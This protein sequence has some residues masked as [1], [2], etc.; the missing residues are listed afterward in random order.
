[1]K[2]NWTAVITCV[3]AVIGAGFASGREIVSFFTRYG[4]D[5]WW[6]ILLSVCVM[7]ALCWLCM[8]GAQRC[9][10]LQNWCL[11][12]AGNG[13]G[14]QLCTAL[15][16]VLAAGAMIGAAGELSALVWPHEWAYSLGAAGTLFAAWI[17]GKRSLRALGWVSGCLTALLL[18][19]MAAAMRSVPQTESTALQGVAK[20]DTWA[21]LR[22]AGYAAMN[23]TLAIGVVCRCSN[24]I[25]VRKRCVMFGGLMAALLYT[26]NALYLRHPEVLGEPFPIVP[27]LRGFGREGFYVS[28]TLLYLAVFTTLTA[29]LCALDGAASE[30]V[31]L[32][33]L[34]TALALGLPLLASCMG[35]SGIV[36]RLY[37]PAGLLCLLLV[38]L[39]LAADE[40]RIRLQKRNA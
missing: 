24:A 27:L 3:G 39:P 22:A 16:L 7:S 36:D 14:A 10:D 35:F 23:M 38:Y 34:R 20:P 6:L 25:C 40:C 5:A 11:M 26:A 4:E 19:A 13:T 2:N 32:R 15:L 29:V 21:V 12:F 17:M 33:W 9:G 8:N 37:A 18:C 31:P 1:M 30:H 28:V